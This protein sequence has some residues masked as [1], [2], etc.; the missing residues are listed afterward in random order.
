MCWTQIGLT[1]QHLSNYPTVC[2]LLG[3]SLAET[4]LGW[5]YSYSETT[6]NWTT[7]RQWCQ[8]SFTDMVVIQSQEE[9][10]YLV[11]QLPNRSRSPYYWIGI[12]KAHKNEAWTWIGNNS[13]WIGEHSWAANEPNNNHSTEFCVEIYVNRSPNRGKWNDEKCANPKYAVCYRAQCSSTSCERGRCQETINNTTCLCE[14]GFKGDRCET[15][16]QCPVL[17]HTNFSGGRMNCS[18]PIGPHSYNSTCEFRCDEGYQLIGEDR[19]R[20]DHSGQ[21]TASIPVCTAVECPPLSRPDNGYLSCSGGN[22]VFN[23]T[24]QFKCQLGH[25]IIGLSSKTFCE[26]WFEN[27]LRLLSLSITC[28]ETEFFL[29]RSVNI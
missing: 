7:A 17:N 10:D 13:T 15:A 11:S 12:T 28:V 27:I 3:I 6:M 8:T 14:P 4:T 19:I 20:C 5:T 2:F 22:Q 25:L 16:E 29:K 26:R 24:C 1:K 18:H 23:T 9:N 21:W